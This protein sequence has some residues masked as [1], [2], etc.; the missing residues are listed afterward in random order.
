MANYQTALTI[1]VAPFV[2]VD[3]KGTRGGYNPE[4]VEHI[5][6]CEYPQFIYDKLPLGSVDESLLRLDQLQP[7]GK[8]HDSIECTKYCLS[9]AAMEIV[10]EWIIWILTGMLPANGI[11]NDVRKEFIPTNK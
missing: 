3:Q 1:L 11:I 7:I 4:F 2:G 10:D 6:C 8:N 9:E 5:R